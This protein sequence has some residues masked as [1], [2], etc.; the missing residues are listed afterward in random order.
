[1]VTN[2]THAVT[3]PDIRPQL[4][5]T[6]KRHHEQSLSQRPFTAFRC[7]ICKLNACVNL[8]GVAILIVIILAATVGL[9]VTTSGVLLIR[10]YVISWLTKCK[11]S[12]NSV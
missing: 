6:R 3:T 2:V 7:N 8:A 9:A 11:Y 12:A 1:M 10:R 5:T 4:P